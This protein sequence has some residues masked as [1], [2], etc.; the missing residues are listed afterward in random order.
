ME[1]N[2]LKIDLDSAQPFDQQIKDQITRLVRT[3][4]CRSGKRL[5]TVRQLALDLE[6][7]ANELSRICRRLEDDG[8]L[9]RRSGTGTYAIYLKE[10]AGSVEQREAVYDV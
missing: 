3:R 2:V 7:N 10:G 4:Q 1:R 9:L 6:L 5:P 8:Y